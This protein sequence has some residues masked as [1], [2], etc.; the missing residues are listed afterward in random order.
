MSYFE[1]IRGDFW[2]TF[3]SRYDSGEKFTKD[4]LQYMVSDCIP[5][6]RIEGDTHRWT[7]DMTTVFGCGGRFFAVDWITGLSECVEKEFCSQ[8][9]EVKL[10]KYEKII[11]VKEWVPVGQRKD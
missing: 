4:E 5:I 2:E 3:C 11:Q 8:P 10:C 6:D 7:K 9:Q 1:R